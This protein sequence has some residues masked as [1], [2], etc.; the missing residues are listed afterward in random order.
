MYALSI[1]QFGDMYDIRHAKGDI[2]IHVGEKQGW[3]C[4]KR[5]PFT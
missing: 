4:K 3:I 2:H 5:L 1:K